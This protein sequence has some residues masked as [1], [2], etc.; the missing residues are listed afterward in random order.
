MFTTVEGNPLSV[1]GLRR[2]FARIIEAAS[3]VR[4][5]VSLHTM[6]H[7][8]ACLLLQ[9]G[10]D[11]VSIQQLLGHNDLATTSIS[12]RWMRHASRQPSR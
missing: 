2:S 10:A 6:R 3:I 4:S 8:F 5:G 7:T 9:G 11:L 12:C 1:G